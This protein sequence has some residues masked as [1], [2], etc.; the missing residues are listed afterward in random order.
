MEA[1]KAPGEAIS[2]LLGRYDFPADWRIVLVYA[3]LYE[4]GMACG[5][6]VHSPI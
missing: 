2:P 1:G 5:N 6:G 3:E 4:P